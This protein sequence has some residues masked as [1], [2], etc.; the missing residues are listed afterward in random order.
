MWTR[1]WRS[2]CLGVRVRLS[3]CDPEIWRLLEVAGSLTLGRVHEVL[4]T[5][6]GREDVHLHRF[7]AA[8]PF[9]RLR[10]V[11]GEIIEPPQWLP[12][13]WCEEP[14]DLAEEVFSLDQLLARARRGP[15]EDTGGLPRTRGD[16]GRPCRPCLPTLITPKCRNGSPTSP[17]PTSPAIPTSWTLMP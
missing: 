10:P 14:A 6:F 16:S 8:D 17:R 15:L 1:F 13:E 7:T 5:A 9:A 3:E 12:A 4:Q 11:D 2:A